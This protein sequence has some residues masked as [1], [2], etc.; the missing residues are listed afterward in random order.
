MKENE[1]K[2]GYY[3]VK[4]DNAFYI[5]QFD[6]HKYWYIAGILSHFDE[7]DFQEIDESP[8]IRTVKQKGWSE[9][10]KAYLQQVPK[11]NR[12]EKYEKWLVEYRYYLNSTN[13]YHQNQAI[14]NE[15]DNL[16]GNRLT[17]E[18]KTNQ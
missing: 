1:R 11:Q 7:H 17:L 18:P 16:L 14:I 15:I 9:E 6:E 5:A 8:I 3:W 4:W 12:H 2:P 10:D 13:V